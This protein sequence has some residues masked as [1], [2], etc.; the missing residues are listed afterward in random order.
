MGKS[1]SKAYKFEN[2]KKN[3]EW[4]RSELTRTLPAPHLDLKLAAAQG[5]I[6]H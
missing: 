1:F 5:Y 6:N 2:E 3:L 4:E